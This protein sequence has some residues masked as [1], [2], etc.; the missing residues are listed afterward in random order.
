MKQH[1]A[2]SPVYPRPAPAH[3]VSARSSRSFL[4][5]TTPIINYSACLWGPDT[6]LPVRFPECVALWLSCAVVRDSGDSCG[7]GTAAPYGRVFL[8]EIFYLHVCP[9]YVQNGLGS[10]PEPTALPPRAFSAQYGSAHRL[11][12]R[13]TSPCCALPHAPPAIHRVARRQSNSPC[14]TQ[15]APSAFFH[16]RCCPMNN[17]LSVCSSLPHGPG[18]T[19]AIR[20]TCASRVRCVW[21][22]VPMRMVYAGGPRPCPLHEDRLPCSV[23]CDWMCTAPASACSGSIAGERQLCRLVLSQ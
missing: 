14:L 12:N 17:A 21:P 18:M 20:E 8:S 16:M 23:L 13:W 22:E 6:A 11:Y 19:G 1:R 2:A 9:Q 7:A 4:S 3:T 10:F 5:A 15:P